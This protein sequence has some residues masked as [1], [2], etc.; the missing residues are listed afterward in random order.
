MRRLRA[1]P[2]APSRWVPAA[3]WAHSPRHFLYSA[4]TPSSPVATWQQG[5]CPGGC[6]APRGLSLGGD[7]APRCRGCAHVGFGHYA[8][9][10]RPVRSVAGLVAELGLVTVAPDW[11]CVS[12]AICAR[13]VWLAAIPAARQGLGPETELGKA[14]GDLGGHP[15]WLN[16]PAPPGHTGG[17]ICSAQ[18]KGKLRH[19]AVHSAGG[20][21]TGGPQ[22]RAS[23]VRG[24]S[25]ARGECRGQ[26]WG[27]RGC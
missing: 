26:A 21:G 22:G 2:G 19:G 25:C 20:H 13:G 27:P 14:G 7:L 6:R 16:P 10:R 12:P 1:E 5:G 4:L 23:V 9:A 8:C 11:R 3:C 17:G 18:R 24:W 15:A